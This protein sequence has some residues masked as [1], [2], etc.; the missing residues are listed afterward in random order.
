MEPGAVREG[1]EF[2]GRAKLRER[3][4]EGRRLLLLVFDGK[5]FDVLAQNGTSVRF[6][7]ISFIEPR[8]GLPEGVP[9]N[10]DLLLR[11]FDLEVRHDVNL[12]GRFDK[13]GGASGEGEQDQRGGES[14]NGVASA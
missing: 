2:L 8:P 12:G 1:V 7:Q 9:H 13:L 4:R 3:G 5:D 11:L 6:A 14:R 10:L